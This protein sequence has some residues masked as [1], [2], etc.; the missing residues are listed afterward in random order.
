MQ[1]N[2]VKLY[3]FGMTNC[4][5]I[6]KMFLNKYC[7]K[8]LYLAT[9]KNKLIAFNTVKP[10]NDIPFNYITNWQCFSVH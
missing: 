5:R 7:A 8:K 1:G 3:T 10:K 9:A 4:P 2:C 6:L